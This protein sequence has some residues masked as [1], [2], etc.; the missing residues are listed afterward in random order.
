MYSGTVFIETRRIGVNYEAY[1]APPYNF[2]SSGNLRRHTMNEHM[3]HISAKFDR[4]RLRYSTNP[5][6][7]SA[8]EYTEPHQI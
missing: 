7:V 2:N 5:P 1:N 6:G 8:V 3:C 4:L